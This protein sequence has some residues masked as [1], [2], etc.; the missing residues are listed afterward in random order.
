MKHT[1][2]YLFLFFPLTLLS[3][4][5]STQLTIRVASVVGDDLSGQKVTLMQT[6]F[7]VS[8]GT[9]TLDAQ[10]TCALKVYPGNHSLT[11]E[12]DGFNLLTHDFLVAEGETEKTVEVTLTERTRTPFALKAE[13]THDVYAGTNTVALSW[14]REEPAFFDDFESYEPFAVSFGQWTGIDADNEAAAPLVGSYPNRGVMQYA[15]IINPLTVEPTWWYDYPILRPYSGQQYVGFT[16][17]SS[18]NANDDWLISPVITVGTENVLS[19]MGKAADRY[20]ERFMVYVMA[21][22]DTL[23]DDYQPVASDFVRI[24]P[25]NYETAD[26]RD[27]RQY[28][29]DLSRYA[30][31]RIR[32]AIRYISHYNRYGSFM[33]MV[34]DVFVGQPQELSRA[35]ARR[36]VAPGSP[37]CLSANP[38][39]QFRVFLDGQLVTTTWNTDCL[40]QGVQGGSHVVGVQ[41]VYLQAESEVATIP[42]DIPVDAYTR[43]VFHVTANSLLT[44]DGQTLS[45][46]NRATSA[47]YELTVDSGRAEV[48]SLP[49]GQ[50]VVSVAEGAFEAWQQTVD[51]NGGELTVDIALSDHIIQPYNIT[52]SADTTGAYVLRW[53]QELIFSDSFEQYDDFAT[54]TFGDWK[55]VDRDLLP[56]YPIALGSAT[57][58]VSFPGSGTASNPVDI[59]PMVFN[60]WHTTPPMLPTDPAIAAPTGDKTVIFFSSQMAQA[61]KWLISPLLDIHDDYQLSV[62]AKAYTAMYPESIEFCISEGSD[63]PDDFYVLSTVSQVSAEQW[64]VYTTDLSAYAGRSVRLAVHYTSVDAFLVQIDD[65]TVGPENGQGQ[66]V[67]YGNVL[68]FDIFVD[69]EKVGESLQPTYVLPQ[70]SEGTHTIGIRAVYK[71]GQ[72]DLAEYVVSVATAIRPASC[73]ASPAS[74]AVVHSLSGMSVTAS[75]AT[76]PSGI[77]LVRQNG[78]TVKLCK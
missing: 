25:D 72:S 78:R 44:A 69:G 77:W 37:Q 14:N 41:A 19:F 70:L 66:Q 10:G 61:D 4:S 59:A 30:G 43:V 12:R 46:I 47:A 60:P 9:L 1:L 74:P 38:N 5:R 16:R 68:R 8:Y 75:P 28:S 55:S 58:I 27:W 48:A 49:N 33:L 34:D 15:Q 64:A 21:V 22:A 45:L 67:D 53:N 13:V 50:Y 6:D 57:N 62:K 76:L 40:L 18:G 63:R 23:P 42:V 7:Q 35:K 2:L 39:E 52:A 51:V 29:Y 17:T 71:N 11:V 24:D 36:A 56:V 54:G 32:F 26:Y 65:F 20:P 31:S 3:Q 73:A